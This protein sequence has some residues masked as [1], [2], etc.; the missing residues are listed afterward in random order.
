MCLAS[1]FAKSANMALKIV[2]KLK[3]DIKNGEFDADFKFVEKSGKNAFTKKDEN[4]YNYY[5]FMEIHFL[6]TF[7]NFFRGSGISIILCVFLYPCSGKGVR[8]FGN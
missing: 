5:L 2:K 7:G 3:K 8:P 6:E 1:K 4:P